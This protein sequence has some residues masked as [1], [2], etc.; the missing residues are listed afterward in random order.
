MLGRG[1]RCQNRQR[2]AQTQTGLHLL[3]SALLLLRQRQG[4]EGA[5]HGQPREIN[6]TSSPDWKLSDETWSGCVS[7]L[8][9]AKC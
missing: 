1:K 2:L 8:A 7:F 3:I 5:V 6:I 9:R 4:L